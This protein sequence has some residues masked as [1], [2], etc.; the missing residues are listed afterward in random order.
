MYEKYFLCVCE[1]LLFLLPLKKPASLSF[2]PSLLSAVHAQKDFSA[3]VTASV[4]PI[5]EEK[6]N[7]SE[8]GQQF[9]IVFFTL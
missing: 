5:M 3:G 7:I 8:V 9:R 1:V 4:E 2:P 6:Q